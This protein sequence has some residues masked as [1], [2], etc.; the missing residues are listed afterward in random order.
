MGV[1]EKTAAET[2]KLEDRRASRRLCRW[3]YVLRKQGAPQG[4]L[5]RG[6]GTVRLWDDGGVRE[7]AADLDPL[8][9]LLDESVAKANPFLCRSFEMPQRSLS[10]AELVARLYGLLVVSLATVTAKGEPRVAPLDAVFL[11]GRFYVPTVA[12][13]AGAA[14]GASVRGQRHLLRGR[15]TAVIVHGE[16]GTG[17]PGEEPFD[18]AEEIVLAEGGESL[19]EWSGDPL[20][21][22]VEPDVI[23]TF[24]KDL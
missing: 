15:S 4:A 11:R 14:P 21:L 17:A 20:F 6:G 10:A 1:V 12:R 7:S 13:G 9:T 5:F 18:E 24:A 2:S 16:A 19:L 23:Y 22:R 8:Q 3:W